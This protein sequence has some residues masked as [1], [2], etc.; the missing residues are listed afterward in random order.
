MAIVDPYS[1]QFQPPN[2]VDGVDIVQAGGPTGFNSQFASIRSEFDTIGNRIG[3]IIAALAQ[4]PIV[5]VNMAL[6]PTLFTIASAPSGWQHQTGYAEKLP[7]ATAASGMMSLDLPD[8]V[9]IISL[10]ITGINQTT[11]GPGAGGPSA[12]TGTLRV[13]LQRQKIGVTDGSNP[14]TMVTVSAPATPQFDSHPQPV[15]QTMQPVAM[16]TYKYFI[17]AQL[18]GA[19][20]TDVVRLNAFQIVYQTTGH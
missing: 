15:D 7:T 11:P 4:K 18:S 6:T 17:V 8:G 13:S 5:T 9:N 2:Y 3:E 12:G 19:N 1:P 10:R 14:D 20:N 16:D